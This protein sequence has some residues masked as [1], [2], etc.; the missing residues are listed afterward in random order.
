MSPPGYTLTAVATDAS[1]LVSTSPPVQI[2]INP[3]NGLAYGLTS[4][5]P[6]APFVN[7]PTLMPAALPGSLPL[8]LSQNGRLFTGDTPN[9]VSGQRS[10]PLC[11]K[12]PL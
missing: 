10:H 6:V 8:L 7:M 12:H 5:G 2:T 1:G 3:G 11:S 9:R 4:N